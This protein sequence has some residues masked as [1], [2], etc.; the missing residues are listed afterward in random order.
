MTKHVV[1]AIAVASLFVSQ[2]AGQ[3]VLQKS[4]WKEPRFE[5]FLPTP[6][7]ALPW[8]NL[9]TR[10]KLPKGDLPIGREAAVGPP[11]LQPVS[12]DTQVSSNIPVD[13]RRM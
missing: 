2:A 1:A 10:T 12:Q 9:D 7:P 4:D 5:M 13:L 6:G 11:V 8:L 3:S